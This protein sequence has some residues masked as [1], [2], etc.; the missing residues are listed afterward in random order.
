MIHILIMTDHMDE[1]RLGS[2]L[3]R[4]TRVGTSLGGLAVQLGA[5]RVLGTKL[6]QGKHA[7]ALKDALGDL[8]GPLMKAAQLLASIP[9]A[10]PKEYSEDLRQLQSNAPPMGWTFVKRRMKSELGP[11]WQSK[12]TSFERDAAAAASLGQVH[13]AVLP[14][15]T[16]VACKLQYPDMSSAV[17]ADLRQLAWAFGV[18][19][20]YDKAIDP[21]GVFE[22]LSARL[23]EE[24]DYIREARHLRLYDEMLAQE[25]VVHIPPVHEEFSSQR[26]LTMTWVNG[27]PLMDFIRGGASVEDRET[28]AQN[29]F[30]AWYVPFYNYGVIHGDPH[31]G[32]Y[33]IRDDLSINMLD[34]GCV[35]FFQAKFVKGVIDLY[36]ALQTGN[37]ELAVSAY[38]AWGFTDITRELIDV[39]H[40]WA[41][42]IFQ[43]LLE[44]KPRLISQTNTGEYGA[45][46][47]RNVHQELKRVGGVKLPREFV[48]MDRAAI[49]LGSVFM[50]LDA[51]INW[52]RMFNELIHDFD[53]DTMI[54]RQK[55]MFG[56]HGQP[57]P[58]EL[59]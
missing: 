25:T 15:G 8:K 55:T 54:E 13:R 43:P 10:L 29:M 39:L 33:T 2:R 36:E 32:N 21:S 31:F 49:G 12:F 6:D 52:H 56:K 1:N 4:Y 11:D 40:V 41:G 34:F 35:R 16:D 51:E 24:L 37:D 23:R 18:Y 58:E 7:A 47:A 57:M 59:D 14:D 26:L 19:R 53:I 22:E 38:E 17:E 48:F 30:R 9:D 20:S 46:V 3:R 42:F 5:N 44:D 28:V 27:T 45:E 50:H